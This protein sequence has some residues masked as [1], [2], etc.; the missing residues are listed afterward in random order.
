MGDDDENGRTAGQRDDR[1][2]RGPVQPQLEAVRLGRGEGLSNEQAV[3]VLRAAGPTAHDAVAALP[4][5]AEQAILLH[6]IDDLLEPQEVGLE[7][8]HVRQQERQ[9]LEPAI[10]QV[11]DV[12]GRD[13]QAIHRTPQLGGGAMGIVNENV[14]PAP[15]VDSTR[16]RPPCCSTIWRA[17]ASPR[18][19]PPLSPR[20][21]ARSTL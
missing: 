12:Q 9:A 15:S 2:M 7:G 18:P 20:T 3:A 19:V 1:P 5:R 11:A 6:R 4:R 8:R 10:G 13:V 21:R 14:L 16:I 17:M